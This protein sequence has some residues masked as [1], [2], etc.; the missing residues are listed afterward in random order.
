MERK[1]FKC[2]ACHEN[3]NFYI[4]SSKNG[5]CCKYCGTF[6]YFNIKKVKNNFLRFNNNQSEEQNNI[7][8][9][10]TLINRP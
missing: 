2:Y 1:H 6:N 10:N 5:N 3:N 4:Q 7:L 8:N 9:Q